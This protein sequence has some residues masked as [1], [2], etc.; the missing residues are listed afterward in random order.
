MALGALMWCLPFELQL[1][2]S[3]L[4]VKQ[5]FLVALDIKKAFDIDKHDKL[6]DG[7]LINDLIK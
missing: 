1:N 3:F 4:K 2:I 5:F 7:I 6:F